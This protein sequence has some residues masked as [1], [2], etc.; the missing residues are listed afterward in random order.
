LPIIIV[1]D[2]DAPGFL[3]GDLAFVFSTKLAV[4]VGI[5]EDAGTK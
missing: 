2:P 1:V 5:D 4:A 3:L